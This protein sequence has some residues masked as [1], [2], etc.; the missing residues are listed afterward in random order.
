MPT[1]LVWGHTSKGK[2][3]GDSDV[4]I[5][6]MAASTADGVLKDLKFQLALWGRFLS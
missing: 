2:D 1:L 4:V 5:L 3:I 6:T